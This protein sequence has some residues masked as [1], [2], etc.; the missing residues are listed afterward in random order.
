MYVA[1]LPTIVTTLFI[2]F[3]FLPTSEKIIYEVSS[4]RI[5]GLLS[6]YFEQESR[7]FY[8]YSGSGHTLQ[9]YKRSI[10]F[11]K[12]VVYR[13]QSK[14]C[15]LIVLSI[16]KSRISMI[17]SFQSLSRSTQASNQFYEIVLTCTNTALKYIPKRLRIPSY[18]WK[19]FSI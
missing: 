9:N 3:N 8:F 10:H 2:F 19:Y 17:Q 12:N 18:I 15:S 5:L 14:I 11:Q 7:L 16:L 6:M 4:K 13:L 1:Y